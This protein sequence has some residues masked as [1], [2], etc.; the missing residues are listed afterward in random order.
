IRT[1]FN[2]LNDA[3]EKYYNPS[4]H[5]AIDKIIV[6]FKRRVVFR[7]YIPKKHERFGIKIFKICDAAGYT[8]D[9]KVYLGKER[10]R[11]DQDVTA[12][13]ATV[14]DLCRCIEGIERGWHT[15]KLFF[16]FLDMTILNSFILLS[17]C[18]TKLSHREFRLALVCN[19]LVHAARGPSRPQQS[20]G[21]PPAVS[22]AISRLEEASRHHWPTSSTSRLRCRVC[23]WHRKRSYIQTKR[24][25]CD[26]GLCISGCFQ[27]F[28]MKATFS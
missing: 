25:K 18:G 2:T 6:K 26:I 1:I 17:S 9:M 19:M 12:T 23:S 8:Y 22:S 20:M 13:H 21:R 5:L 7:Q 11:A 28:H 24:V 27:Q 10:T 16:H 14:R 4:E 3:Y 15:V